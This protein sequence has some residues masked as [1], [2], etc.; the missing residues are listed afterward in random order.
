[1]GLGNS[2]YALGDLDSAERA[3][4]QATRGHPDFAPAFNNL[5]HVLAKAGRRHEAIIAAE[6]AAALGGPTEAVS[7]ATLA[8]VR[9]TPL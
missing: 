6:R 5:A 1:M 7:K 8:E 2:H 4:R 3:F 9:Q